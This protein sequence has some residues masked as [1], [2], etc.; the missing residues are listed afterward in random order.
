MLALG[1]RLSGC[2]QHVKAQLT[3]GRETS[4]DGAIFAAECSKV[5]RG[6]GC[7]CGRTR[8][9]SRTFLLFDIV[10]WRNGARARLW[11]E[12]TSLCF[13]VGVQWALAR[14]WIESV[15]R[16]RVIGLKIVS[17]RDSTPNCKSLPSPATSWLTFSSTCT[18]TTQNVKTA[19][20]ALPP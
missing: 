7:G 6:A 2:S 5:W 8:Q 10:S 19:R 20:Q 13:H 15:P 12:C 4:K 17:V 16:H 3:F 1:A 11:T 14:K 9:L 18:E